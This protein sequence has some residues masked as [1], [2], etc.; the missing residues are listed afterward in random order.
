MAAAAH[1]GAVV[2]AA[3]AAQA[4]GRRRRAARPALFVPAP[5]RALH[6][7]SCRWTLRLAL[8]SCRL[9]LWLRVALNRPSKHNL[10]ENRIFGGL[11]ATRDAVPAPSR[12]SLSPFGFELYYVIKEHAGPCL[13]PS[14]P[15]AASSPWPVPAKHPLGAPPRHAAASP[16]QQAASGSISR[17]PAWGAPVPCPGESW[18]GRRRWAEGRRCRVPHPGRRAGVGS[19][20]PAGP[21]LCRGGL[22]SRAACLCCRVQARLSAQLPHPPLAHGTP[23]LPP[24]PAAS[25]TVRAPP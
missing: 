24:A 5:C 14:I 17:R 23:R 11:I 10:A 1:A 18:A 2:P 21:R 13:S 19:F 12:A 4:D 20:G 7:H 8:D 22:S 15:L 25:P 16:A 9:P 6:R 3:V